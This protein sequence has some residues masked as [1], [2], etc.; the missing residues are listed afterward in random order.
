VSIRIVGVVA[1]LVVEVAN[2][3][4]AFKA[5]QGLWHLSSPIFESDADAAHKA[6]TRGAIYKAANHMVNNVGGIGTIDREVHAPRLLR[7]LL[8]PV[9]VYSGIPEDRL[10]RLDIAFEGGVEGLPYR[11]NECLAFR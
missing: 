10:D 6:I 7:L 1:H 11:V 4:K 3:H 8:Y 5:P 2:L 9:G